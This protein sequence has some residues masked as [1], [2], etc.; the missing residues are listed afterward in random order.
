VRCCGALPLGAVIGPG[1]PFNA[2]ANCMALTKAASTSDLA[3]VRDHYLGLAL[4]SMA[5]STSAGLA[6]A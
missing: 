4:S 6:S 5:K 1:K 2:N 3:D